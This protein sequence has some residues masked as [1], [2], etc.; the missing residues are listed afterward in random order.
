MICSEL[1]GLERRP[2]LER[3]N[4]K[5]KNMRPVAVRMQGTVEVQRDC[6]GQRERSVWFGERKGGTEKTPRL[7]S[8]VRGS[9]ARAVAEGSKASRQAVKRQM[10]PA[11]RNSTGKGMSGGGAGREAEKRR[12]GVFKC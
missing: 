12:V 2:E 5:G 1:L 11:L 8:A 6:R 9:L 10:Q 3:R 4:D 7:G